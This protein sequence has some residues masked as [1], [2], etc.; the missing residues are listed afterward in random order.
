VADRG[1]ERQAR[2]RDDMTMCMLP[3][4]HW[5]PIA[6]QQHS[7]HHHTTRQQHNGFRY[8]LQRENNIESFQGQST[9][10]VVVAPPTAAN[11]GADL[12]D[13]TAAASAKV[14]HR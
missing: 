5:V 9:D 4:V 6:K 14:Q 1:G 3:K 12:K 8:A 2:P 7:V 11:M 13:T 10:F